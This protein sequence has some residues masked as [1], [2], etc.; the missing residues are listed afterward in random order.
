MQYPLLCRSLYC[1]EIDTTS[2]HC[3]RCS[4]RPELD[5]YRAWHEEAA[6]LDVLSIAEAIRDGEEWGWQT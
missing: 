4:N 1:G 6:R 5:A 3:L 2:A